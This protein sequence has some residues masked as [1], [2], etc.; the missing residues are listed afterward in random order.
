MNSLKITISNSLNNSRT[1][2]IQINGEMVMNTSEELKNSLESMIE[3]G[4][5]NLVIDLSKVTIID[6]CGTLKLINAH[7]RAKKS[8]GK[9]ILYGV[10]NKIRIML[11]S[12]GLDKL[13]PICKN[14][15]EALMELAKT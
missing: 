15:Q 11:D 13:M 4:F 10:N 9:I 2:L 7:L 8:G 3:N 6:S 14:F 5:I 1:K 12:V